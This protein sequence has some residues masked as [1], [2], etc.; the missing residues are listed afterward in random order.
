VN[1]T[2]PEVPP[3][4]PLDLTPPL[5]SAQSLLV[6]KKKALR[7]PPNP[8]AGWGPKRRAGRPPVKVKELPSNDT[9]AGAVELPPSDQ[10]LTKRS[11]S[12]E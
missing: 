11:R 3:L 6:P 10:P 8:E 9:A 5:S 1:F 4:P 7:F 2:L 12:T